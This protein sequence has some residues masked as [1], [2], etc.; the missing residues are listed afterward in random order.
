MI[1][2]PV[3]FLFEWD[4]VDFLPPYAL[5]GIL[6]QEEEYPPIDQICSLFGF[7][8]ELVYALLRK[9]TDDSSCPD[10]AALAFVQEIRDNTSAIPCPLTVLANVPLNDVLSEPLFLE[11]G[12][13]YGFLDRINGAGSCFDAVTPKPLI[14]DS[15]I[16]VRYSDLCPGGYSFEEIFGSRDGYFLREA[17]GVDS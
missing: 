8:K 1:E 2:Q 17:A 3:P 10:P 4:V 15:D 14:L 13:R 9:D 7:D 5:M 11:A 12:A 6:D 16:W